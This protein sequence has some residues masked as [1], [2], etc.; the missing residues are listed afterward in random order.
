LWKILRFLENE[1]CEPKLI[2]GPAGMITADLTGPPTPT[3]T[4]VSEYLSD[5]G[6]VFK[7][8][9][10]QL[11][12]G[13]SRT[14]M[15]LGMDGCQGKRRPFQ[16]VVHLAGRPEASLANTTLKLYP[17]NGVHSETGTLL[18]WHICR[19]AGAVPAELQASRL[20]ETELGST[21]VLVCFDAK[22]MRGSS[23][24]PVPHGGK[25][26][27]RIRDHFWQKARGTLEPRYV[28]IATHSQTR[29]LNHRKG[30]LGFKTT[31]ESLNQQLSR[32]TI[33]TTMFAPQ[34]QMESVAGAGFFPVLGPEAD[35]VATLLV[36]EGAPGVEDK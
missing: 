18:G 12:F 26:A 17:K 5:P 33:I 3:V 35:T 25:V 21:L 16:S 7:R 23:T 14:Q 32:T 15:L 36:E 27:N 24:E 9:L 1:R 28:L 8:T 29:N 19:V 22:L 31:A 11:D 34:E 13:C 20:V 4:A 10:D 6:N 30:T 2:V